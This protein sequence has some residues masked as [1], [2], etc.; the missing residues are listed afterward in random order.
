MEYLPHYFL[1]E[2]YFNLQDCGGAVTEWSVSEQQSALKIKP[3]FVD[4]VRKGYQE[5]AKKGVLLPADYTP[6]YLSTRQAYVDA[7]AL[8][9]R[10]SDLGTSKQRRVA[11]GRRRSVR[12]SEQGARDI[13]RSL[14]CGST[15]STGEP[16]STSRRPH[17]IVPSPFCVRSRV[18]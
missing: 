8:A 14:D 17:R 7:S 5:C 18:R 3:E 2:A 16:T 4:V 13:P 9:K 1:G 11:R 15:H 6:L 10:V 12:K